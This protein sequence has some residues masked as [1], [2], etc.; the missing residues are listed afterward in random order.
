[1]EFCLEDCDKIYK[2]LCIIKDMCDF[3]KKF[4]GDNKDLIVNKYG[5][6]LKEYLNKFK[7]GEDLITK[8]IY[9]DETNQEYIIKNEFNEK[10]NN[11]KDLKEYVPDVHLKEYKELLERD[12]RI[13]NEEKKKN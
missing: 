12:E 5:N 7:L 13:K 10:L 6:E 11:M 3:I 8:G 9:Y 2:T 1:M 4:D